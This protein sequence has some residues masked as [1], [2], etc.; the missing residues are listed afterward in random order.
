M[1]TLKEAWTLVKL[2][3]TMTPPSYFVAVIMFAFP[4]YFIISILTTGEMQATIGSELFLFFLAVGIPYII[5]SK[6]MQ[7]QNIGLKNHI[8]PMVAF[9]QTMP[10]S[11]RTIATYRM[12]SYVGVSLIYNSFLFILMYA[13]SPYL[14]SVASPETYIVFALIWICLSIYV[15]GFQVNIEAGYHFL[16]YLFFIFLIWLPVFMI[17]S[18]VLFYKIYTKGLIQW[19]LD[20]SAA[21]PLIV[22][23]VSI[24]LA[25]A[26]Y[27]FHM[28]GFMKRMENVDY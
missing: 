24:V 16:T 27:L 9:L 18:V 8:S 21:Y 12:I 11:K 7:P 25:V 2:E 10:I 4:L 19:M 14:R 20:V 17:I 13:F 6:H 28:R 23:S 3:Y 22:V 1:K 5:R 15:G 26:G